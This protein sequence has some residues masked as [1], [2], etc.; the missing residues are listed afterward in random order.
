MNK[1]HR[2]PACDCEGTMIGGQD[3]YTNV[4]TNDGCRVYTYAT[5]Y[6]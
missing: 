1:H 2:C 3:N 6:G 4:C 5:Y